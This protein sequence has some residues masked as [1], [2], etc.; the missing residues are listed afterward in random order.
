MLV[1]SPL[2]R[3]GWRRHPSGAHRLLRTTLVCTTEEGLLMGEFQLFGMLD[4][5]TEAALRASIE[6][7]G[8]VVPVT[9]DQ[10]GRIIDGHH[11]QR[12]GDELGVE[13]PVRVR[14]VASDEEAGELAVSLN[15][16]RR[17]LSPEV[18]RDLA[19]DLR[20][21]GFSFRA[22]GEALGVSH[23]QVQHDLSTG[24][25]LPVPDRIVGRDGKS[26]P[27][28]R[29]IAD[30]LNESGLADPDTVEGEAQTILDLLG[31]DARSDEVDDAVEECIE[32][33]RL[34][35]TKPD[36]G[37]GVSHP[38]RYSDPLLDHFRQM[39]TGYS[40]VLDPFAGTGRIHELRPDWET[41]GVEL[42][43][44]WANLSPYT[45]AGNA[46]ALP[47]PD[48]EFDAICTSPTYGNRLADHHNASDP[49]LRRSYT[50][51]LGRP[52]HQDNSGALHWGEEY[53]EFH[54]R[55]WMEAIRVLRPGGRFVVN[56]KDHIRAGEWQDVTV[57]HLRTLLDLGLVVVFDRAIETRSLRQG[58]NA[59]LRVAG[60]HI[61]GLDLP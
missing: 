56:I 25:D 37:G 41:T 36:L 30:R 49:H 7:F 34:P 51:D 50:H 5:A 13:V 42:E 28:S 35:I 39:L 16:D 61:L 15:N 21:N 1:P 9:V 54:R 4:P 32:S 22:I 14:P 58:M 2:P 31:P 52:L 59:D 33:K 23:V 6:R 38:A 18:R 60:E 48:D 19:A 27:S 40:T 17:H 11:R 45:V 8:V 43:P 46:L 12:I 3:R 26:R 10:H 24:K 55:A 29:P 20:Q 47:F 44:E 57:W 53:R